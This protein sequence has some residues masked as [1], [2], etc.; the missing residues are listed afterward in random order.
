MSEAAE[1]E[2]VMDSSADDPVPSVDDPFGGKSEKEWLA[3]YKAGEGDAD[4]GVNLF[5]Y[6]LAGIFPRQGDW[7][8]KT[9]IS[10]EQAIIIASTLLHIRNNRE[11]RDMEDLVLHWFGLA[12]TGFTS[13]NGQAR[14]EFIQLASAYVGGDDRSNSTIELNL[15][16][17]DSDD[18]D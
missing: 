17:Q 7:L 11:L 12:L 13:V 16:H 5:E 3:E 10:Y 9:N 2:S 8:A 15:A 18:A 14:T 4:E 6:R 1:P